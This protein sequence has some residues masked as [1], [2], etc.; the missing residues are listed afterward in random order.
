MR[1]AAAALILAFAIIGCGKPAEKPAS[2]VPAGKI[3]AT[4]NGEPIFEKDLKYSLA[5]RIKNDPSMEVTPSTMGE[6]MQLLIDERLELQR[7]K[8]DNSEINIFK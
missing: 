7:K 1:A 4:V 2:A 8:R 6:Q 3:I 5:L